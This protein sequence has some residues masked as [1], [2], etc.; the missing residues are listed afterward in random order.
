MMQNVQMISL[1]IVIANWHRFCLSNFVWCLINSM[2]ISRKI[3]T[4]YTGHTPLPFG[5]YA[6]ISSLVIFLWQRHPPIENLKSTVAC[7]ESQT[8]YIPELIH[9]IT[10]DVTGGSRRTVHRRWF[11]EHWWLTDLINVH[12]QSKLI[13]DTC[14]GR[15]FWRSDLLLNTR[16]GAGQDSRFDAHTEGAYLPVWK[17]WWRDKDRWWALAP[18]L[19]C[20]FKP[21]FDWAPWCSD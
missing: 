13:A 6:S 19:R 4:W 10:K 9:C 15:R 20:T 14:R 3:H 18:F 7:T 12:I 17:P 1:I 2:C 5:I 8:H 21:A 16:K 11:S